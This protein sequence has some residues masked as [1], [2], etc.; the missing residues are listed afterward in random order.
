VNTCAFID[1]AKAESID[2]LLDLIDLKKQG[3]LKKI[4]VSGCL[5]QRY[6]D[7]LKQGFPEVNAFVGTLSLNH[8][9]GRYPLTGRHYGYLKICE[10][11]INHCSFC[12][13]P[14]IK[15]RFRSLDM[16]EV[17]SRVD[18]F[19]K[20]KVSELNIIGQDITGYGLDL[21]HATKLA[22]LLKLI[23]KRLSQIRWLRL[24]YLYPSRIT[25][26]LLEVIKDE[27]N[28]C[29]Y[30]DL[31]I[32][33]INDRILKLMQRNTTRLEIERLIAKIR[34]K[35]P[36]IAIRTSVIVGF[37]S[38]TAEEFKELLD[39]IAEQRFA[40]LGA[41][42]YSREEGTKAY[43][44]RG[45]IP[46]KIRQERFDTLMCKQQELSK[47][48]NQRFLGKTIEVLID[49]KEEGQATVGKYLYL[50]RSQFDAP[51]VDG[52]VYVNSHKEYLPGEF[53]QVKITDTL[54]YDLVGEVTS[55]R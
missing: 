44:F 30:I 55:R 21:Y 41:F 49:E 27:A 51:E 6:K 32:Q 16:D 7:K 18:A 54:E 5:S 50:G 26:E 23:S 2:V 47:E 24:L 10:G 45:Q 15:G 14:K 36:G 43:H 25:D 8:S 52:L 4:I 37:P 9:Q 1:D 39:F 20:E 35:L 31:P 46:K 48:F 3:K 11:C 38:E 53:V 34:K 17:L 19:E 42:L 40:R 12:I 28:I 22:E 33:H 13:I 29:R